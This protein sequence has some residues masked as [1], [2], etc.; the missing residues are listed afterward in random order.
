MFE[1]ETFMSRAPVPLVLQLWS[2]GHSGSDIGRRLG[3]SRRTIS[4]IIEQA[5]DIGDRRSVV[6]LGKNGQPLGRA[7]SI[8][9]DFPD[10]ELVPAIPVSHCRRGHPRNA[11]TVDG[12]SNCR[13]CRQIR[14]QAAK[15]RT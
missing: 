8:L 1:L 5:R 10:I 3:V 11:K 14:D 6:H 9:L 4:M 2:L 7:R 15:A 12:K 13:L